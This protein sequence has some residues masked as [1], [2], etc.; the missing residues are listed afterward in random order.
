V[1]ELLDSIVIEPGNVLY[2]VVVGATGGKTVVT[3]GAVVAELNTTDKGVP[4][5]VVVDRLVN[6]CVIVDES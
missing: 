1:V 4:F 2:S 3:P 5:S 6:E